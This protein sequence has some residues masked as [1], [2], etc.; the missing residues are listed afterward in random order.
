M[1]FISEPGTWRLITVSR[2]PIA[3]KIQRWMFHEVF[4]RS[5]KPIRMGITEGKFAPF[6]SNNPS[7]QTAVE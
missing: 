7:A 3:K 6:G 5:A 2:E 4:Q 1:I